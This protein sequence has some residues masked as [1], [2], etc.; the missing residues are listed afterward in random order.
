[1]DVS[2]EYALSELKGAVMALNAWVKELEEPTVFDGQGGEVP[3]YTDGIPPGLS[4]SHM[5][6]IQADQLKAELLA[7]AGKLE[8]LVMGAG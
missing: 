8:A 4:V 1:M 3:A 2:R 6:C 7:V 5:E